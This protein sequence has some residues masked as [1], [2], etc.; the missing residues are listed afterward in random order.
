MTDVEPTERGAGFEFVDKIVGGVVPNQFI[1]SVQK[2]VEKQLTEGVIA[3]YPVV[4]VRVTLVDGKFH[5]VD[6]SDIA[7]QLAG[8]HGFSFWVSLILGG[9]GAVIALMR[10]QQTGTTLPGQLSKLPTVG[11]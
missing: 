9:V 1:P 7:F 10:A 5:P 4:D 11:R 8:G 3:G 2:G 6:S